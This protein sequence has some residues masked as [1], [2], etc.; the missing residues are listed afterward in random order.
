[1]C[2][3]QCLLQSVSG[4]PRLRFPWGFQSSACLMM[5]VGSR[6]R[7]CLTHRHFRSLMASEIGLC[8]VLL[9]SSLLEMVSGHLIR[10]I[11]R[12]H[13]FTKT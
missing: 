8:C 13:V 3:A 10:R 4:R 1:M 2:E 11:C 7:L 9:Q 5:S 6:R 12:R